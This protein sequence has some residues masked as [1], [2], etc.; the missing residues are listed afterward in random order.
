MK[1]LLL[2]LLLGALFT[3]CNS[4]NVDV[5]E[6]TSFHA[7]EQIA[8]PFREHGYSELPSKII[9]TQRDLDRLI[10]VVK[11]QANWN[12]KPSFL[13]AIKLEH[14]DFSKWNLLLYRLTEGS[15]SVGLD[16]QVKQSD[17]HNVTIHI[18]RTVPQMGTADMAY[19]MLAYKIDKD[20]SMVNFEGG[21]HNEHIRN[22]K[23]DLVIAENCVAWYDGCNDCARINEEDT[24]CTELACLVYRPQDFRCTKW[25]D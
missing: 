8:I 10:A 24:V 4:T 23:A 9:T 16:E 25:E 6:S 15:G 14:I 13:K 5:H 20:V 1:I 19:Y 21:Q 22:K 2:L 12:N 11:R 18:K 3:A 7:L 17:K